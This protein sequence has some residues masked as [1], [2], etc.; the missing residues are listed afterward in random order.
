MG[1][2][3]HASATTTEAVRRAIQHSQESLRTLARRYGINQKP[4]PSGSGERPSPTCQRDRASLAQTA[5]RSPMRPSSL[6]SASTRSC[7]STIAS[8]HC[9]PPSRTLHGPRCIA[10]WLV[11]AS[12]VCRIST[13]TSRRRRGSNPTRSA[14]FTSTLYRPRL[15][16]HRVEA[17]RPGPRVEAVLP[18]RCWGDEAVPG[19]YFVDRRWR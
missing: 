2:V 18:E 8:M 7:H 1:K 5:C 17:M 9:R 12:G 11:T 4:S 16:R 15:L 13:A 6:P 19:Q 3:L 10:A 14:S